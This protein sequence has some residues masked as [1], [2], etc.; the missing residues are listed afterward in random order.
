MP[1]IINNKQYDMSSVSKSQLES[2][3]KE[4][5]DM[6]PKELY[7]IIYVDP[8]WQYEQRSSSLAN[9]CESHYPTMT[10]E[11]LQKLPVNSIADKDS[12]LYLW[13]SNPM[14]P[15]AITLIQSWGFQYKTVFKVW[16]KVN[17]DGSNVMVPG[18]WSRSSTELLLVATKGNPLKKYKV[19]NHIEQ[20]EFTS[21]RGSHSEKPD[22]IR[23]SIEN[24]MKVDRKIELFSRKIVENWDVWGLEIP[25]FFQSCND[26]IEYSA[27]K[28]SIGIQV[29]FKEYKPRKINKSMS[30][31]ILTN[32]SIPLGHKDGCNCFVCKKVRDRQAQHNIKCSNG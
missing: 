14:L 15:K 5:K 19:A 21:I 22:E 30:E 17:A 2:W 28:R 6:F 3:Q 11:S 10:I 26:M 18:W 16:R 31:R 13:T 24:F 1:V 7:Q 29:C 20:Q 12:C 4:C 8:P 32:N 27:D 25:G 9:Q 23:E